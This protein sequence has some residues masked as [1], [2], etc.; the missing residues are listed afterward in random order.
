MIE[1]QKIKEGAT[2]PP[3]VTVPAAQISPS[4]LVDPQ[5][6]TTVPSTLVMRAKGTTP[7]A[8]LIQGHIATNHRDRVLSPTPLPYCL[9]TERSRHAF[10][11][12][13]LFCALGVGR[14]RVPQRECRRN[15]D[16][17]DGREPAECLRDRAGRWLH[18][19]LTP[20]HER[21]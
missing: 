9:G 19:A 5:R 21:I 4:R 16:P 17:L 3:R 15:R 2:T 20:P 8:L 10:L 1:P 14:G 18:L 11:K 12:G 13:I 6:R 7:H